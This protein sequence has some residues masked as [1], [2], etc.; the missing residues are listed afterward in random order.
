MT[1]IKKTLSERINLANKKVNN[2]YTFNVTSKLNAYDTFCLICSELDVKIK[3]VADSDSDFDS[4]SM[5]FEDYCKSV[6]NTDNT[7][8]SVWFD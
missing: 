8:I 7:Q 6:V 2:A 3:D 1:Q 4:C 5:I